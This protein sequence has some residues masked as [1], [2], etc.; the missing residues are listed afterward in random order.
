L[1]GRTFAIGD[2]HGELTQLETL[3]ASFPRL[4]ADDTIV[5]LGDYVD[6]GP[7][8]FDVVNFVRFK[9]PALGARVVALRGNHEDGWV[10]VAT[11][12]WPEFLGPPNNGCLA[13][14][15]SYHGKSHSRGD[16][17]TP[18]ERGAFDSGAFFPR[19]VLQWFSSLP[20]WYEDD[21][22]I[23]VHAGLVHDGKKWLHPKKVKD[24]TIMLWVRT[25]EF[26]R[27]YKGK[28][29]VV[30]HTGTKYLPQEFSHFTPGDPLDMWAGDSVL[31]VDTGCGNGGFLTAVELPAVRVYETRP[32]VPAKPGSASA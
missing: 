11:K 4:D 26:F 22:A 5:L 3:V 6:R 13:T 27:D 14:L 29:V 8:S 16:E 2:I 24:P 9:L 17:P 23:Y 12:G 10:R 15:R 1:A 32:N 30:G 20:Y 18:D 7:R 19:D 31:A 28:R 25:V 21:H